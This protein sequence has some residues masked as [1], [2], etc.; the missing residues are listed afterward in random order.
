MI[1][2]FAL[3]L[4]VV[5]LSLF[6]ARCYYQARQRRIKLELKRNPTRQTGMKATDV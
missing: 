2:L 1:Y 5:A 3:V 4:F 6:I